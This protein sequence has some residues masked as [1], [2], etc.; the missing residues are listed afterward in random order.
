M[1]FKIKIKSVE[2]EEKRSIL[3]LLT[4]SYKLKKFREDSGKLN[5]PL[6]ALKPNIFKSKRPKSFE[7]RS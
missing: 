3:S 4:L 5:K 6:F 2:S 1:K 7:E